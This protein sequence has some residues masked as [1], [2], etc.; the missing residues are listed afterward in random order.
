MFHQATPT[1]RILQFPYQG[2]GTNQRVLTGV[3]GCHANGVGVLRYI[4]PDQ[5]PIEYGGTNS[6]DGRGFKETAWNNCFD[7]IFKGSRYSVGTV[8]WQT[9]DILSLYEPKV[10]TVFSHCL[11]EDGRMLAPN[12]NLRPTPH[13]TKSQSR[14]NPFFCV[15]VIWPIDLRD[16]HVYPFFETSNILPSPGPLV[17][18]EAYDERSKKCSSF[19]VPA[20]SVFDWPQNIDDYR[21][22]YESCEKAAEK[23]PGRSPSDVAAWCNICGKQVYIERQRVEWIETSWITK[24]FCPTH[25]CCWITQQNFITC[26]FAH[27]SR[28]LLE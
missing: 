13:Q 9:I 10:H 16:C 14:N 22:Y 11:L 23:L 7:R 21:R 19:L 18:S 26:P 1:L 2:V 3:C 27:Q 15:W 20:P 8:G 25:H 12:S 4:H 6:F 5:L 28:W 24:G 17:S